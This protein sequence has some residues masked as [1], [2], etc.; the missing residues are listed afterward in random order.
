MQGAAT[1]GQA[2]NAS[3]RHGGASC[4]GATTATSEPR[5]PLTGETRNRLT[6][7][8]SI[9]LTVCPN[10]PKSSRTTMSLEKT[11]ALPGGSE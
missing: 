3:A 6:R 10:D 9:S 7:Y 2:R 11:K 8:E 1:T 4:G 5:S